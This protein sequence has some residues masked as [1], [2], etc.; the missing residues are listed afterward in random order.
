[1]DTAKS[2]K[3]ILL[4]KVGLDGH[5]RGIE[6]IARFLREEGHEVIYLGTR[7][8]PAVVAR[9]VNQEDVDL[10]GLS[11]QGHEHLHLTRRVLEEMKAAGCGD[12]PML[13]GGVIPDQDI[14]KL[15]D[16]GVRR[17]FLPGTSLSEIGD[18]V[19]SVNRNADDHTA[20][21]GGR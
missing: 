15:L 17:V 3:R 12:V 5:D 2:R 7:Q 11:F 1:M 10:V 20:I 9:V 21:A 14:Q 13:V 8:T 6:I 18:F 19:A 4:S 16:L